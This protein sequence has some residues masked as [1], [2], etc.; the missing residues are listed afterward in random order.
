MVNQWLSATISNFIAYVDCQ[1]CLLFEVLALSA[2]GL[3]TVNIASYYDWAIANLGD[4]GKE[5]MKNRWV[6]NI[7]AINIADCYGAVV[8]YKNVPQ[9]LQWC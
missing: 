3:V 2:E 7:W 4:G 5:N 1:I 6:V 8:D 9:D